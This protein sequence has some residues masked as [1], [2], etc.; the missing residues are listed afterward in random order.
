MRSTSDWDSMHPGEA[1][2]NMQNKQIRCALACEIQR[3]KCSVISFR[4][5]LFFAVTIQAIEIDRRNREDF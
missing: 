5:Y 2:V 1:K 3:M 4:G